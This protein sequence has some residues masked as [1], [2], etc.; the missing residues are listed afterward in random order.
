MFFMFNYIE[1]V[2]QNHNMNITYII[3]SGTSDIFRTAYEIISVRKSDDIVKTYV[4]VF[5]VE[6]EY[7]IF[8]I[9]I[10]L[11]DC[12]MINVTIIFITDQYRCFRFVHNSSV[13]YGI[14]V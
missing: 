9:F 10:N 4:F 6:R 2:I 3:I 5:F 12:G 7:F 14:V 8:T 13:Y 11:E 1:I